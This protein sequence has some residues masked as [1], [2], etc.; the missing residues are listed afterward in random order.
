MKKLMFLVVVSL[1]VFVVCFSEDDFLFEVN[2]EN[3][4]IIFELFVVN[5]LIDGIGI[6]MLVYS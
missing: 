2:F 3:V 1:F 6:W 5:G 4:V